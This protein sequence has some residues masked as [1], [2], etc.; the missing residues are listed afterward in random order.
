MLTGNIVRVLE[1]KTPVE[2]FNRNEG[3]TVVVQYDN[4]TSERVELD[5]LNL[6]MSVL[7]KVGNDPSHDTHTASKEVPLLEWP[8]QE[9]LVSSGPQSDD[10]S[11]RDEQYVICRG[12]FLR[13]KSS[14][15]LEACGAHLQSLSNVDDPDDARPGC[16]NTRMWD[17]G[18]GFQHLSWDPFLTV[19]CEICNIDKDDHQVVICDK[20]HSGFHT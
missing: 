18:N 11:I 13:R 20:C 5:L 6:Q 7:R 4:N 2:L 19:M 15:C 10:N 8:E 1:H 14:T 3:G 17:P 12:L 16:T 9:R